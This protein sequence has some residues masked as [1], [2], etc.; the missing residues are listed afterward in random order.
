MNVNIDF[1]GFENRVRA[2]PG[3]NGN[4]RHLSA[5]NE[6]VLYLSGP[7]RL[8]LYNIDAKA[9]QP[10]IEGIQEYD[11]AAGL[12]HILFQT[13]DSYGIAPL[14]PGQKPD[15]GLLR[16]EGLTMKLDPKAE[17]AEMYTDAWRTMRDWFY[18]PNMHGTDWKALARQV[19]RAHPLRRQPRRLHVPA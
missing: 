6:G 12:K 15:A 19:R 7:G 13:R 4:Y 17:W 8:L 16:L 3:P 1:E 5:T 10:I 11:L 18:D 14:A 2:I 9:E